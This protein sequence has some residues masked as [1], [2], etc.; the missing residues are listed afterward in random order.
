MGCT[1]CNR[2][3]GPRQA[4]EKAMGFRLLALAEAKAH[5][6]VPFEKL[7]EEIKPP[8]DR[9]YHPLFQVQFVFKPALGG[10]PAP[11]DLGQMLGELRKLSGLRVIPHPARLPRQWSD[12]FAVPKFSA[13]NRSAPRACSQQ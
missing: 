12:T 3:G 10:S 1:S 13:S 5:G 2:G 9:S 7:I 11:V 4:R 6:E 8:R